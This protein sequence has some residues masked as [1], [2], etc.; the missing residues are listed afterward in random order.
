MNFSNPI[1]EIN[2]NTVRDE[3]IPVIPT[4]PRILK[5]NN[6]GTFIRNVD[7]VIG[8][9]SDNLNDAIQ[10]VSGRRNRPKEDT[11]T[12]NILLNFLDPKNS[13][14]QREVE[15]SNSF[16]ESYISPPQKESLKESK[17]ENKLNEEITK[18]VFVRKIDY[19]END[20]VNNTDKLIATL[21]IYK[22]KYKTIKLP[23]YDSETSHDK[24]LIYVD[25]AKSQINQRKKICK[26]KLMLGGLFLGIELF[27]YY[28][29]NIDPENFTLNQLKNMDQYELIFYELHEIGI[30]R[31]IEQWSPM[32][33]ILWIMGMHILIFFG[34]KMLSKIFGG[35][36][37]EMQTLISGFL[38]GKTVEDM[39]VDDGEEETLI[40]KVYNI[41]K[42]FMGNRSA[43]IKK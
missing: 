31:V 14:H 10:D 17:E 1:I 42:A 34:A 32:L 2:G 38:N 8:N 12:Q 27:M 6:F 33:R 26:Y 23:K 7:K 41:F 21:D 35:N 43:A 16:S 30:E 40:S 28:I 19:S 11:S 25:C 36:T 15:I 24:L 9:P 39:D 29:I 13:L 22:K 5:K 18:T 20:K 3:I 4:S 37:S